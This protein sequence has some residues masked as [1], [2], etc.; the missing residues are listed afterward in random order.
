MVLLFL[1]QTQGSVYGHEASKEVHLCLIWKLTLNVH[2]ISNFRKFAIEVYFRLRLMFWSN[3]FLIS[4]WAIIFRGSLCRPG[5]RFTILL[6]SNQIIRQKNI[7]SSLTFPEKFT[8]AHG[9]FRKKRFFSAMFTC[10]KKKEVHKHS[11][12]SS[13]TFTG[14]L[15][16]KIFQR[17]VHLWK[18]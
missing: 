4:G 13:L 1:Y 7:G 18:K 6:T 10:K 12:R 11:L 8:Y 9:K 16:K 3:S 5:E 2:V 15:E 17:G 14:S